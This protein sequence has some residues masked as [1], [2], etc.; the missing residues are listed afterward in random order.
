MRRYWDAASTLRRPTAMT[1]T[2]K[3]VAKPSTISILENEVP[4]MLLA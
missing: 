2:R 4:G 1:K 3:K